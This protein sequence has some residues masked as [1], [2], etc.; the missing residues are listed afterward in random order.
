MEC[1]LPY[2]VSRPTK[3]LS[4]RAVDAH[5][6]TVGSPRHNNLVALGNEQ[7]A[8][9]DQHPNPLSSMGHIG[10][11]AVQCDAASS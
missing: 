1:E 11:I 7:Q 5:A 2:P 8:V 6:L 3:L 9:Q 4:K 10:V